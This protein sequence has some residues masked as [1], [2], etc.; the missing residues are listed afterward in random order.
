MEEELS[1]SIK[2]E[3]PEEESKNEVQATRLGKSKAIRI[4]LIAFSALFFITVGIVGT[5]FYTKNREAQSQTPNSESITPSIT[6]LPPTEA[7]NPLQLFTN[8]QNTFSFMY[9]PPTQIIEENGVVWIDEIISLTESA[10]A[11]AA[12]RGACPVLEERATKKLGEHT[13]TVSRGYVG[14]IGGSTP[15]A[16]QYFELQN[17]S[18][19]IRVTVN[20]LGKDEPL[21]IAREQGS[22]PQDRID[23]IEKILTTFQFKAGNST[24][25]GAGASSYMSKTLG[26]QF[27]YPREF[28]SEM[29]QVKEVG[30]K[31]Y[32]YPESMGQEGAQS[33]EVFEKAENGPFQEALEKRFLSGKD[34]TQC[35][36]QINPK[37]KGILHAEIVFPEVTPY[38]LESMW[39]ASAFCS[40]EYARTNGMRYF[41]YDPATPTKYLFFSIGQYGIP[42]SNDVSWQD[43]VEITQ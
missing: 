30:S 8:A 34:P 28:N 5:V 19:T 42:I 24:A 11:L 27:Q 4:L 26:I 31:I 25:V 16:Q 33:V 35:S 20:E 37:E 43:T 7:P 38:D 39:D 29:V 32:V 21:M 9:E 40:E 15:Q 17:G 2:F 6:P 12:C 23:V 41:W 10:V 1:G 14:G 3:I 22:I 18:T 13:W 36:I